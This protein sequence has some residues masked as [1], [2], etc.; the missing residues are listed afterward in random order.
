[1]NI[2][3]IIIL[4]L[5][6]AAGA[7]VLCFILRGSRKRMLLSYAQGVESEMPGG[8][9]ITVMCSGVHGASQ[10]EH[11]LTIEFVR[12][13]VVVVLDSLRC[14]DEFQAIASRYHMINVDYTPS[15]DFPSRGVRAMMRSRR[16]SFR[17][18]VL[19]DRRSGMAGDGPDAANDFDVAADVASYEY[20]LPVREGQYL[21]FDAVRRLVAELGE[22]PAGTI[23]SIRAC[24]GEPVILVN[25]GVA[26]F[27][28]SRGRKSTTAA[29]QGCR[30]MIWEPIMVSH[31][32]HRLGSKW[33]MTGAVLLAGVVV[34]S[35]YAGW[36]TAAAVSVTVVILWC[37][38]RWSALA[39]GI[40][41]DELQEDEW[42]LS[43]I[44]V[45]NFTIS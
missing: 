26:A 25:R 29:R 32:P 7:T 39:F 44:S 21:L 2:A 36:W 35:I 11:L 14:P 42:W 18:L 38:R 28:R 43:K 22:A 6:V 41:A 27:S 23:D 12:Y 16:R 9:G 10:I 19:I 17:R 40:L 8:I 33:R 45:K 3:L 15:G 30:R 5:T 31:A 37:M 34:A 13:E 24:L 1:M 20:L 4:T